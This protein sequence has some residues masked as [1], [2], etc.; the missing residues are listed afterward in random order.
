MGAGRCEL[1]SWVGG[2]RVD[3]SWS[4]I[5]GLWGIAEGLWGW[6]GTVPERFASLQAGKVSALGSGQGREREHSCSTWRPGQGQVAP[7]ASEMAAR[8]WFFWRI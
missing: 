7:A 3:L 6:L 1:L 4:E 5:S 2:W 8:C